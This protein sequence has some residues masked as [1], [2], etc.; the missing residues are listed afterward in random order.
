MGLA[1]TFLRDS[2]LESTGPARGGRRPNN[3]SQGDVEG[4]SVRLELVSEKQ[5]PCAASG[6]GGGAGAPRQRG[7]CPGPGSGPRS[8]PPPQ[9]SSAPGA[10]QSDCPCHRF[11]GT[12]WERYGEG[13]GVQAKRKR[14]EKRWL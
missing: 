6:R 11:R 14:G 5:S 3:V 4:E 7:P 8:A 13:E 9:P 1:G 10:A 12:F 2:R